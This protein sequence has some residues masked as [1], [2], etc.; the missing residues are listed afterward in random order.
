MK[1]SNSSKKDK[2]QQPFDRAKTHANIGTIGHVHDGKTTLTSA[3]A[4]ILGKRMLDNT[5]DTPREE[6]QTNNNE[7]E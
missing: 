1:P 2:T 5:H 7:N 3:I 6:K 4:E